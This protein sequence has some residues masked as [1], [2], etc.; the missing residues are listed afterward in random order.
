MFVNAIANTLSMRQEKN[1]YEM[2]VFINVCCQFYSND[3][4]GKH[5]LIIPNVR[6]V[7]ERKK[8]HIFLL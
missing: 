7:F 5:F 1:P 3:L 6:N 2:Y 4:A 8:T